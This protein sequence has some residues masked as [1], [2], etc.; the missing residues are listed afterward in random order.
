MNIA[1]KQAF[2]SA[3]EKIENGNYSRA[4]K[5]TIVEFLDYLRMQEIDFGAR[6]HYAAFLKMFLDFTKDKS[7][8][9]CT[10][11]DVIDFLDFRREQVK[12]Y[13][14]H[15]TY[16]KLRR[17]FAWFYKGKLPFE[18]AQIKVHKPH[19]SRVNA[20]QVLTKEEVMKLVGSISNTR[21]K[22]LIYCLWESGC[23]ISE[24]LGIKISDLKIDD[25]IVSFKVNGKTGER[26]CYL[27][28]SIPALMDWINVHPRKKE[29]DAPLWMNWEITRGRPLRR[30]QAFRIIRRAAIAA[31][32]KKPVFLHALR[33]SRATFMAKQGKNEAFLRIY[34]GWSHSSNQPTN[35][36]KLVQSDIKDELLVSSGYGEKKRAERMDKPKEC[37]RCNTLNDCNAEY[38]KKCFLVIDPQKAMELEQTKD[39]ALNMMHSMLNNFKELEKKG[40]DLQQFSKFMESW[41]KA[42]GGKHEP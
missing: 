3:K 22:A 36:V 4:N 27:I 28:E 29:Q 41:A 24:F 39:T 35:Y 11:K 38:C 18:F 2:E 34:F 13:T 37:P 30:D 23:R 17:F 20:E 6:S 8:K 31:D 25:R 19:H 10:A 1:Y 5:E 7:L 32:I 12:P 33:H 21:D 15:L 9:K 14:V 26:N 16:A 40:F 42:N